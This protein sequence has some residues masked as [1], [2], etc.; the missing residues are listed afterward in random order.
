MARTAFARRHLASQMSGRLLALVLAL[1]G[2]GGVLPTQ[3]P[4][5][6]PTQEPA[7]PPATDPATKPDPDRYRPLVE[8]WLASDQTDK[9]ALDAA[10][11]A[12]LAPADR[13]DALPWLGTFVPAAI[14]NPEQPRSK[15]LA[16]LV[17][18]V[19]L[20]FIRREQAREMRYAGQFLPLAS[21]QP[22]VGEQLFTLLLTTPDWYPH[23][24]RIE[25]IAPLRDLQVRPPEPVRLDAVARLGADS[26]REPMP[27]RRAV[28]AL[29]WGWG[30]KEPAQ[31]W[32]AELQAACM[33]G[34]P[35]DRLHALRELAEFQYT[36]RDYAAAARTHRTLQ[37]M[38]KS[39]DLPL[40]PVD[41]YAAAC[42]HNLCGKREQAFE[43][44]QRCLQQLADPDLDS[45]YRLER[46]LFLQD[47]EIAELR[48][49][50]RFPA[51][52]A[53]AMPT[54]REGGGR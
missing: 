1:P 8:A 33:E 22:M 31:R 53:A 12:L 40:K 28:A 17:T 46:E 43:L 10:V 48:A 42:A 39:A 51:L 24:H 34:D 52:L 25:L 19:T 13:S 11:G 6:Q 54:R 44:L 41:L 23:T 50:P 3:E 16:S 35:A 2:L 26:D 36:L 20:E 45:S 49:D 4:I 37:A 7:K 18:H 15:G 32:L 29:L 47:P 9:P 14:A 5:E 21:L 27:L 38:A 30:Q